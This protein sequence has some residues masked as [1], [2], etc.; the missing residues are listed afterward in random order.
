MNDSVPAH[1]PPLR[2]RVVLPEDVLAGLL[3]IAVA[4]IGLWVSR[5]Y[6]IGTAT[7]MST[8]Y[9]PRLL[10]WIMLGLGLLIALTSARSPAPKFAGGTGLWRALVSVPLALIAFA[11]LLDQAG[12]IVSSAILVA[13]GALA[14]RES[15]FKEAVAAAFVLSA[16]IWL[17][18]VR[19]LGLSI[20]VWPD[21]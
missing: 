7:R 14:S 5:D 2:R 17:I 6:P 20:Q 12:L 11:L 8:G 16:F 10:C 3:F 1:P 19:A 9:V 21:W 18:F 15:R 13:I 4:V